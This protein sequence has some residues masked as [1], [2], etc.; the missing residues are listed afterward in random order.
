MFTQ[1]TPSA[2]S[3][4]PTTGSMTIRL[5]RLDATAMTWQF[6]LPLYSPDGRKIP[7]MACLSLLCPSAV[8]RNERLNRKIYPTD[9]GDRE[10]EYTLWTWHDDT[11]W[12]TGNGCCARKKPPY[13]SRRTRHAIFI[14]L[15]YEWFYAARAPVLARHFLEWRFKEDLVAKLFPQLPHLWSFFFMWE[16]IWSDSKWN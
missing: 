13:N 5:T 6:G 11:K 10:A 9:D 2:R 3:F 15:G 16:L 12:S 1:K 7:Q 14:G 4:Q 8:R